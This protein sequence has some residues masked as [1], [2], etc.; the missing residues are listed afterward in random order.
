MS[1]GP[2]CCSNPPAIISGSDVVQIGSLNSYVS[3][4]PDSNIGVILVS[5][6]FGYEAPKLRKGMLSYYYIYIQMNRCISTFKVEAVEFAKPVIQALIEKGTSKVAAAGF[7]WGELA[8]TADIQVA[9]V[10]HPSFVTLDDIKGVKVPTAI[11]GAELD[12][13]CPPELVKKFEVALEANQIN[14]TRTD[15]FI[16]SRFMLVW[17][18]GMQIEHFVKIYPGVSHGWTIRYED[19]DEAA[20]KCAS[21]AQQD[22]VDWFDKCLKTNQ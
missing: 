7:C 5:D 12:T 15:P 10:L 9:A 22:L 3:G 21:E 18:M 14:T 17:F 20:K 19:D 4:N 11:L 2:E 16:V 8:K 13:M 6:V 1:V